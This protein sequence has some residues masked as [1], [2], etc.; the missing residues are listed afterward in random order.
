MDRGS[1]HSRRVCYQRRSGRY[2]LWVGEKY[3]SLILEADGRH[4]PTDC[5]ASLGVV[6]GLGLTILTGWLR[7]DPIVAILVP[8]DILWMEKVNSPIDRRVDR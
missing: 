6:V 5:L 3:G 8:L 4:V 1:A 7:F 2:L